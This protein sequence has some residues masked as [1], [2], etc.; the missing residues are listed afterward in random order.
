MVYWNDHPSRSSDTS[1]KG[2][3][4]YKFGPPQGQKS[5]WGKDGRPATLDIDQ[6]DVQDCYMLASAAAL[7]IKADRVKKIFLT[8]E[9]NDEGIYAF[10]FFVGGRPRVVTIDDAVPWKNSKHLIFAQLSEDNGSWIPLLEKAY[11]KLA[12]NYEKLGRG[13]M[14]ESMRVFT[15]APSHKFNIKNMSKDDLWDLMLVAQENEY[16][17][18]LATQS[19]DFGLIPAHAYT[20][21]KLHYLRCPRGAIMERLIQVHN[22]WANEYY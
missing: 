20:L 15:G 6:G 12:G 9:L 21:V 10:K 19:A 13:W 22:P 16:P 5:L 2:E 3:K 1:L 18:T 8:Q 7:A 14:S 17:M 11:A 4:A